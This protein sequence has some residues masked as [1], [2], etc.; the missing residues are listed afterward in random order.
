MNDLNAMCAALGLQSGYSILRTCNL[1]GPFNADV[2]GCLAPLAPLA[3]PGA[4]STLAN[5]IFNIVIV[6]IYCKTME[7]KNKHHC[8]CCCFCLNKG[9]M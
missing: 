5:S 6:V 4:A 9:N 7:S 2:T 1:F 3:I 8:C